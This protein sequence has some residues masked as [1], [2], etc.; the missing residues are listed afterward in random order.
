M[1]QASGLRLARESCAIRYESLSRSLKRNSDMFQFIRWPT[2][3]ALATLW[4]CGSL[5]ISTEIGTAM[6]RSREAFVR[7]L[8][9]LK[10]QSTEQL[11]SC[12]RFEPTIV[13]PI[14]LPSWVARE[15]LV[16]ATEP[17]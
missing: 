7:Q 11:Q 2:D 4:G 6:D 14:N 13:F 17:G 12:E 10:A 8:L 9:A 3:N 15:V 16:R 1:S 5:V